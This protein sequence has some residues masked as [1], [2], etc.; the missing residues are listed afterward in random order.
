VNKVIFNS[1]QQQATP[2]SLEDLESIAHGEIK[3]NRYKI[4]GL[5]KE[6]AE[7]E[8]AADHMSKVLQAEV[9]GVVA[10]ARGLIQGA[11]G[12]MGLS[13]DVGSLE[14]GKDNIDDLQSWAYLSLGP[15]D[16]LLDESLEA[17]RQINGIVNEKS[18]LDDLEVAQDCA[19]FIGCISFLA[20]PNSW[21]PG[22]GDIVSTMEGMGPDF[23]DIKANTAPVEA[24]V[25][26]GSAMSGNAGNI[27]QT[28]DVAD[29]IMDAL[30]IELSSATTPDEYVSKWTNYL[31]EANKFLAKLN[32]FGMEASDE[33]GA[34]SESR[35]RKIIHNLLIEKLVDDIDVGDC[36]L[37]G[38]ED[39]LGGEHSFHG[40]NMVPCGG[41]KSGMD[42]GKGGP[43]L[44]QGGVK[45]N[46]IEVAQKYID[47]FQ[48]DSLV[49]YS[50]GAAVAQQIGNAPGDVTYLAP[51]WG[52]TYGTGTDVSGGGKIYHGGNDRFVPLKNSCLAAQ[53]SGM[54]LYVAPG[55]GHGGVLGDY[56]GGSMGSY[57]KFSDVEIQRCV[58]ELESWGSGEYPGKA[59]NRIAGQNDWVESLQEDNERALRSLIRKAIINYK[60]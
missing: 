12:E 54:D 58:D 11:A 40:N 17:L 53:S 27:G 15:C 18:D 28:L 5:I 2:V 8:T 36:D 51:A 29:Q 20:K 57:K 46:D 42:I 56:K 50:R 21:L 6:D 52:R 44:G 24:A 43:F 26:L 19:R 4:Q 45:G 60:R 7:G 22:V 34:T 39:E 13:K 3:E 37:D 32:S 33:G 25:A 55:R 10:T 14:P 23:F 41:G 59:D 47:R 16:E 38:S 1:L 49:A 35:I 9:E 31:Q 48:P 30:D